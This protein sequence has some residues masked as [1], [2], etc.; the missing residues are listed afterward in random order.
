MTC[1]TGQKHEKWFKG[2][3]IDKYPTDMDIYGLRIQPLRDHHDI[4]VKDMY[5][6]GC[7]HSR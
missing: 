6:N 4:L 3:G 5:T 7:G 2:F 1:Y